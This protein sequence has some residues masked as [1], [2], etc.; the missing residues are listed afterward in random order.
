MVENSVVVGSRP[1]ILARATYG[2][3]AVL[4]A[5]ILGAGSGAL[6]ARFAPVDEYSWAG[7]AIAP[8]W[9]V[10]EAAFESY[11]ELVGYSSRASRILAGV[12]LLVGFYVAWYSL[13]P[14]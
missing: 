9:M 2:S 4:I 8:L 5:A 3:T 6:M 1:S 14:W 11:V 7:L 13:R 10:V 12:A